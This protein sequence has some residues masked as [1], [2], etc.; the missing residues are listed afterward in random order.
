METQTTQQRITIADF[1]MPFLSM[2]S[3]MV[4][5]TIAA[6]PAAFI[7]TVLAYGAVIGLGELAA[8]NAMYLSQ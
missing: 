5:V 4:K 1:D 2:V 7:L 8:V 6:I 3:F